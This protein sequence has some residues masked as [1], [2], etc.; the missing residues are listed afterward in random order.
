M[1]WRVNGTKTPV[2]SGN[3]DPADIMLVLDSS[4]SISEPDWQKF[5]K[6]THKLVEGLPI[7]KDALRLGIIEYNTEARLV[8]KLEDDKSG[9]VKKVDTGL[10][11]FTSGRTFTCK[12]VKLAKDELLKNG[13]DKGQPKLIILLTDGLPSDPR[14]TDSAFASA[15]AAGIRVQMV[16]I[17]MIVNYMPI[18][19]K[20]STV[21]FPPIKVVNGYTE[22]V[23]R[24]GTI[25][26]AIYKLTKGQDSIKGEEDA[27]K[28]CKMV[29]GK[30]LYPFGTG[31][32]ATHK[33]IASAKACAAR[34]VE[35]KAKYGCEYD[36][37]TKLCF[38][39]KGPIT[40]QRSP[41]SSSWKQYGCRIS[42]AG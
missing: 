42:K 36:P 20:W 32:S 14:T 18:N 26:A 10:S 13:R 30:A 6:F 19:P 27:S 21:G 29:F 38:E 16:T 4:Q 34:C 8:T 25:T 31:A 5:I 9:I 35:A 15:H 1:K 39:V 12:A 23:S 7:S 41:A 24:I 11:K 3:W 2:V 22:L 28:T 17:G 40:D 33:N 37:K